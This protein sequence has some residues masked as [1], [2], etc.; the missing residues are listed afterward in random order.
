M[1]TF[2][3]LLVFVGGPIGFAALL[4]IAVHNRAK[5]R[6]AVYDAAQ[7]YLQS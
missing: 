3:I 2:L 4:G 5:Q 1:E 7:K 6:K